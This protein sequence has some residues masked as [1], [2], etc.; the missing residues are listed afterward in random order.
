[1]KN[2][3]I[4]IGKRN[5]LGQY[6]SLE[7]RLG[8]ILITPSRA[9]VTRQFWLHL[10]GKEMEQPCSSII[11]TH[12]PDTAKKI[13]ALTGNRKVLLR[14][15][16]DHPDSLSLNPLFHSD[17]STPKWLADF[18]F[19]SEGESGK[20]HSARQILEGLFEIASNDPCKDRSLPDLY[21]QVG[22]GLNCLKEWLYFQEGLLHLA[23]LDRMNQVSPNDQAEILREIYSQL[24]FFQNFRTEAVF[25]RPTIYAPIYYHQPSVLIVYLS[26]EL[27][28]SR[29][30]L[31]LAF[32]SIAHQILSFPPGACPLPLY[33]HMDEVDPLPEDILMGLGKRHAGLTYLSKHSEAYEGCGIEIRVAEG[34]SEL[35]REGGEARPFHPALEKAAV[36]SQYQ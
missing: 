25:S 3:R 13:G 14:L 11:F 26:P 12:N 10:V 34:M 16:P 32:L 15:D 23:L 7:E 8:H 36:S 2:K 1:M 4:Y 33:F 30:L 20:H 5:L 28:E 6:L 24:S 35:I 27:P 29:R 21:R 17:L 18:F 19:G 22:L 31:R 9:E